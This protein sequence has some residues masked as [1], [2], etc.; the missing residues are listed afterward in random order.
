MDIYSFKIIKIYSI[1]DELNNFHVVSYS[2]LVVCK[3]IYSTQTFD[4]NSGS[5]V[6]NFYESNFIFYIIIIEYIKS[7]YY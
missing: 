6:Q 3:L 7:F 2:S 4:F 5:L 1:S